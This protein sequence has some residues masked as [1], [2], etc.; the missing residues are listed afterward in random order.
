MKPLAIGIAGL[1]TVASGVISLLRDKP[2]ALARQAGQRPLRLQRVASRRPKPDVDLGGAEFSTDLATLHEPGVDVVVELIGGETQALE[3]A[4]RALDGGQSLVTANKAII[5]RNGGELLALARRR[6]VSIG[7]EASVA[8]GIPILGSLA[9]GLSANR[10]RSLAGIVNGTSNYILSAMALE[11]A[12]FEEALERAQALGFAEADPTYDVAGIDAGHKLAILAAL[13]F[14]IDFRFADVH[15]EGISGVSPEDMEYAAD[16][17]YCIKH[18]ALA[19]RSEA[20]IEARVHPTLIP[21]DVLLASVHGVTNAVQV[22]GDAVGVC[23]HTGPG[24]GALPTASA[25]L[26]DIIAIAR[27]K[28]PDYLYGG[29]DQPLLPIADVVSAFYLRIPCLDAPGVLAEI[30]RRLSECGISI[31]GAIQREAAVRGGADTPWVPVVILT[32]P[33]AESVMAAALEKLQEM[34]TVVGEITRLWVEP[35]ADA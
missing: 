32:A 13:A 29:Q 26:G 28:A 21:K 7:F 20:G 4:R 33:V 14:D 23:L 10:I 34:A 2:E 3:L 18:L 35:M 30:A 24:A 8:G 1:G 15:T 19:R 31:E 9:G 22:T 5:A 25:V 27:G 17:G 12:S 16:L 6:A 11:G